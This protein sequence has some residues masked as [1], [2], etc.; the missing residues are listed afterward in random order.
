MKYKIAYKYVMTAPKPQQKTLRS[1]TFC[2]SNT[3]YSNNFKKNKIENSYPKHLSSFE[4]DYLVFNFNILRISNQIVKRVLAA[5]FLIIL[6]ERYAPILL[7]FSCGLIPNINTMNQAIIKKQ[8]L[9]TIK[10]TFE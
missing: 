4:I 10:F 6:I 9:R 7:I 2:I 5:Y 1:N 3:F 8:I